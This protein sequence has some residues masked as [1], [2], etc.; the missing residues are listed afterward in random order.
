[1]SG[2]LPEGR[3]T[4]RIESSSGGSDV[5]EPSYEEGILLG[6]E[7]ELEDHQHHVL[8]VFELTS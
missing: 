1:M 3:L 7:E 8:L 2:L 4:V 5:L 6:L